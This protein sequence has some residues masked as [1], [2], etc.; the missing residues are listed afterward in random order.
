MVWS[1]GEK[2]GETMEGEMISAINLIV[3]AYEKLQENKPTHELLKFVKKITPESLKWTDDE[4]LGN[5]FFER[6]PTTNGDSEFRHKIYSFIKY[7]D[8]LVKACNQ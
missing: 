5:E 4:A 6:F 2:M 3:K 8:A 1:G 7:H